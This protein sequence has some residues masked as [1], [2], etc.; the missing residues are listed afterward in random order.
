[1]SMASHPSQYELRICNV[2]AS[3]RLDRRMKLSRI[4]Q[5]YGSISVWEDRVFRKKVLV[6]RIVDPKMSLLIYE[7][8]KVICT[9]AM[10]LK[11]A[12]QSGDLLVSMLREKG[13]CVGLK[14]PPVVY[15]IVAVASYSRE[16]DLD[17]LVMSLEGVEYEP[18]QFPG[19]S[20]C[21][22]DFMPDLKASFLVF[23]T[24]RVVC[25]GCTDEEEVLDA[26]SKLFDILDK[27]LQG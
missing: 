8:G 19:A 25:L 21:L 14:D 10:S 16:V 15:N 26:V 1:M 4:Y 22:R 20:L 2:V 11:D 6:I 18:E 23:R 24:G 9:G 13:I 27:V 17:A 5:V 7:T 12:L 3:F